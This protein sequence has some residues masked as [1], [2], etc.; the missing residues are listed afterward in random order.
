MYKLINGR[1][2]MIVY[3]EKDKELYVNSGWKLIGENKKKKKKV[4]E[5]A[6]DSKSEQT[7]FTEGI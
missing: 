5:N 2:T 7:E 6:D 4:L 1:I 3:T